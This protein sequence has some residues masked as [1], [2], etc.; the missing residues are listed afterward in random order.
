MSRPP[1]KPAP[2]AVGAVRLRVVRGPREDGRWYWR[3]G[4]YEAGGDLTVWCGW[5]TTEE[6]DAAVVARLAGL[7]QPTADD[8]STV[9]EL[10]VYWLGAIEARE[11]LARNT[12]TSYTGAAL[13]LRDGL[14]TVSVARLDRGAV[15]RYRDASIRAGRTPRTVQTDIKLLRLAWA[16]G[17]EMALVPARELPA[18]PVRLPELDHYRVSGEEVAAAIDALEHDPASRLHLLLLWATG[19]RV[20]EIGALRWG[21]VLVSDRTRLRVT[22]KRRARVVPLHPDAA[23]ELAAWRA[24]HERAADRTVLGRTPSSA[25]G[26][27]HRRLVE[28]GAPWTPHDLR[29]AAVDRLYRAGVDVGTAAALMGHSPQVALRHYRRATEADLDG[30][31]DRAGMG[32]LPTVGDVL[33]LAAARTRTR[34]EPTK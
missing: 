3:A 24:D 16:W 31:I 32:R 10:L 33:D 25:R 30:A 4:R 11:D 27:L 17:V 13:R 12:I 1:R 6:A 18:V 22:G 15:E 28:L 29:R 23:A 9:R 20:S 34:T 2:R 21:D 7:V 19:C 8:V 5:A 26:M 14:G